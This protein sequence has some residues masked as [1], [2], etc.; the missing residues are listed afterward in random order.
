MTNAFVERW[1][2]ETSPFH[3]PHGEMTTTLDDVICLLHLLIGGR[4][5]DHEKLEKDEAIEMLV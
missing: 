3:L 5:L 1:H 2:E 4:F